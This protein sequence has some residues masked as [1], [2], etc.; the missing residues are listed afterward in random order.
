M[1]NMLWNKIVDK[2]SDLY[3]G[4][5]ALV[6]L[7]GQGYL[8]LVYAWPKPQLEIKMMV[9][10]TNYQGN[11]IWKKAID[12]DAFYHFSPVAIKK[13]DSNEFVILS[14]RWDNCDT[15]FNQFALFVI[16]STGNV[17]HNRILEHFYGKAQDVSV[18]YNKQ[19]IVSGYMVYKQNHDI[20]L[21]RFNRDLSIDTFTQIVYTYDTLCDSSVFDFIREPQLI[22][23]GFN[24]YPNPTS[25]QISIEL[26]NF[27]TQIY[28][29]NIYNINGG[30]LKTYRG[31]STIK[32][33]LNL[34]W[35]KPGIYVV[36]LQSNNG[37]TYNRKL[38]IVPK[39]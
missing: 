9:V 28:D 22:E 19:L 26:K 2:D 35:L 13:I 7:E 6:E 10:K 12:N 3:A 18:N 20:Y 14:N 29:I 38:I 8:N 33:E 24:A 1:G 31:I 36:Q 21:A 30:L 23:R 16:D 15:Y 11:T 17:L 27:N 37:E 25:G 4:G 39:D 34:D 5:Q 32:T